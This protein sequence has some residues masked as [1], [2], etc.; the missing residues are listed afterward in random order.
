MQLESLKLTCV[1]IVSS[2]SSV[3]SEVYATAPSTPVRPTIDALEPEAA[4]RERH[5]FQGVAGI[6]F[7]NRAHHGTP[8]LILPSWSETT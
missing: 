3:S 5:S 7:R 2:V 4:E 8:T 6:G 1:A